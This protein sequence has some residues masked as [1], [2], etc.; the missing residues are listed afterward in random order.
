MIG[1][2][3]LGPAP[4]KA[5]APKARGP[6]PQLPRLAFLAREASKKDVRPANVARDLILTEKA[7]VGIAAAARKAPERSRPPATRESLLPP[8]MPRHGTDRSQTLDIAVWILRQPHARARAEIV[9]R[10]SRADRP[11]LRFAHPT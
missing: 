7:V 3:P 5:V 6:S 8:M 9:L 10:H 4:N 11:R 2:L 1:Q